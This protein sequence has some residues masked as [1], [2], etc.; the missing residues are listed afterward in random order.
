MT[1]HLHIDFETRSTVDL[2]KTGVYPYAQ[3]PTTDVW[4]TC[5]AL[6]DGPIQA[7]YPGQPV[8][9]ELITHVEAGGELWSHN[10]QFERVMWRE[11]LTPRYGWPLPRLDQWHCTAAMAASMSLPR[12]LDGAARVLGLDVRKDKEGAALMMRMARPRKVGADG[13]LTWWDEPDRIRRLTEY[14]AR[15]VEVERAL[16]GRLRP[17]SPTERQIYLLDQRIN[18]RGIALDLDLIQA[19]QGVADR[20]VLRLNENLRQITKGRVTAATKAAELT[21]WLQE[22]GVETDSVAKAAVRSMLAGGDVTGAA[23]AAI[24]IRGEAAKSSTAKLKAM[25]LAACEDG[26][27]RGLLLYHGAGTGRWSGKLVQPQNFPRG[28][29]EMVEH[30]ID[31]ILAGDI[32]TLEILYAPALDVVS[33]LLRGCMVAAD[34]HEFVCADF[35]NIEGRVNA[36][37]AGEAW[38]V[39]AFRA[40]DAGT[41]PDLY[42][43][44]YSRSFDVP[45]AE[46]TKDQ[47]Q[48]GKVQE[49][50]LGYQGGV[51]AF[52]SMAALYGIAISDKEADNIKKAWREAHPA[53]VQLWRDLEDGAFRAVIR[54]GELVEVARGRIKFRVKGG[55][56]WMILPSGRPLAYASPSI[57]PKEMPWTEEVWVRADEVKP[58]WKVLETARN[59]DVLVERPVVKDSVCYW[60]V[61]SRTRQWGP[62]FGYGGLWCENAIQAIARDLMAESMLRLEAAGYPILLT[63][64]DEELAEVPAGF[65]SVEEFERIMTQLPRWAEGC[66]IAAE[67]WR[68]RRY[69]K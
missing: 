62:Q 46:I 22:Q 55:F 52:Q 23:R 13:S 32:D 9:A 36:W 57:K 24:E 15:D 25:L 65:G 45:V 6:G 35:S 51:G 48:I 66:P 56:L 38:K 60:G 68:G 7:W 28:T 18:D 21:R 50:A 49:L 19:A 5:W 3:H 58:H 10:A 16:V 54:P 41:G 42:K 67:G 2:R 1:Q 26:R 40:Y 29:V 17:L 61:D 44:A 43:L 64:H 4:V 34:G 27:V 59:G 8:P 12:D 39:A 31:L 63:V 20:A 37:L 33:S 14:C 11:I 53:I 69:R 47:R 30:A